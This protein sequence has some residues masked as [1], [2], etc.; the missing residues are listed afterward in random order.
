M[1]PGGAH[2]ERWA[3]PCIQTGR[4]R[5]DAVIG[6]AE[7]VHDQSVGLRDVRDRLRFD[8]ED[9]DVLVQDVVVLDVGAHRERRGVLAAVEKHGGARDSLQRRLSV[10][11]LGD[12]RAQRSL[13]AL[14]RCL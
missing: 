3:H 1:R 7:V 4:R 12:E 8:R 10:V 11:Q 5:G 6:V 13:V 9:D 2:T 14:P